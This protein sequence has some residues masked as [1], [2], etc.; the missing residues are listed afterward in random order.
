MLGM[1]VLSALAAVSL[2]TDDSTRAGWVGDE[3]PT[4]PS[5]QTLF[6]ILDCYPWSILQQGATSE[7]C[8][9]TQS[10]A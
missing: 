4:S 1:G 2:P 9:K 3:R 7:T 6:N 8:G 5:G 10:F